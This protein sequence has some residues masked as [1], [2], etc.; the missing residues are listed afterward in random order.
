MKQNICKQSFWGPH[1]ATKGTRIFRPVKN[2]HE[3]FY[4]CI[5]VQKSSE[6]A[7]AG[8]SCAYMPNHIQMRYDQSV[9]FNS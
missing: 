9:L 5:C 1:F 4:N 2:N 3:H 8:A 7:L 6:R